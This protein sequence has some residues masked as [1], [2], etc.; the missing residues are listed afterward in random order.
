MAAPD[1]DPLLAEIRACRHCAAALPH[2]PRPVIRASATA[3]ILI[4]GQAPGTRV[5]ASGKPFTDPSGDRL[6]DWMGVDEDTFYDES[7][8]AIAPMGFCFPGLDAKGGDLPP[9]RECAPLWQNRV[10]AALPRVG[11]TLLVGQY[12]QRYHLGSRMHKTLTETVRNAMN[13]APEF[14]PLPHPSWR[15]NAWIRK[16]PWFEA[17]ILPM[18]RC[19]IEEML[20]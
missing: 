5:H 20:S 7:R 18:L 1:L 16:N 8:I 2:E 15:N 10:R 3:R 17:K 6:R 12:S 13:Y 14:L 19:R 9:R 11:L 4:V